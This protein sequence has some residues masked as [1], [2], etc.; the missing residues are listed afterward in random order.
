MDIYKIT[1]SFTPDNDIWRRIRFVLS[2]I[3]VRIINEEVVYRKEDWGGG[4]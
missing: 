4:A 1:V 2:A 3:G